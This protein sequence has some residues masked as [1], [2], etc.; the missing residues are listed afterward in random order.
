MPGS[1]RLGRFGDVDVSLH[2]TFLPVL[3]WAAWLGAIQYGGIDGA[4]FGMLAVLLL[5]VC[6]LLHELA[7]SLQA[8]ACGIEVQYI[9]LLPIGGLA[10][11]DVTAVKAR[12]EVRIA[13]SGP[14]VNLGLGAILSA[15]VLAVGLTSTLDLTTLTLR[16]L[17][18]PSILGL[19]IYLAMANLILGIF[20]LV[21]AFPLDGGRALRAALSTH[22]S[23]EAATHR[24]AIAGRSFGAG[25]GAVG[26]MLLLMGGITYGLALTIVAAVLYAGATYEDRIVR[27][28]AV[29]HNWTVGQMLQTPALTVRPDEPLSVTLDPITKGGV[30]PVIVGEQSRLVGLV[31]AH[32]LRRMAGHSAFGDLSVAHVMRTRFPSVLP[33]DPLWIAYEKLQRFQLFTLP[34]VDRGSL[35]GLVTLS[36][37]RR[38][39]RSGGLPKP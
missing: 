35:C 12:D 13:L 4:A 24:A 9:V 33:S 34:V 23:F 14:L 21:P 25:L 15:I 16:S 7:H 37:I 36:D 11:L 3:A 5:F 22:M 29:L 17:Q 32:E 10:S 2:V 27:R 19:L 39:L 31:T 30:V 1:I 6:V 8:N 38:V 20:N 18:Q 26:I 28:H